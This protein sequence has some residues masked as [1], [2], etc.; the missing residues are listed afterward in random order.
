MELQGT[1]NIVPLTHNARLPNKLEGHQEMF[2][3]SILSHLLGSHLLRFYCT[4]IVHIC[5]WVPWNKCLAALENCS[6]WYPPPLISLV[7]ISHDG[8]ALP[9]CPRL[10]CGL[11]NVRGKTW[12]HHTFFVQQKRISRIN[13]KRV[14]HVELGLPCYLMAH[15]TTEQ[16][17][18]GAAAVLALSGR[19][20]AFLS[21]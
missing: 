6:F 12:R 17:F 5:N 11:Q 20:K 8:N 19:Q 13:P 15:S 1:R 2:Q 18:S 4:C 21:K 9:T 7:T 10:D 16:S 3:L 14:L